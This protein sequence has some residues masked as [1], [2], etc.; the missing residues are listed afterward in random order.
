MSRSST[1]A[2]RSSLPS[3]PSSTWSAGDW[4]TPLP[5]R[6]GLP[7]NSDPDQAQQTA[8]SGEHVTIEID[9]TSTLDH[10]I[11]FQL[12]MA[13]SEELDDYLPVMNCVEENESPDSS[14]GS[15]GRETAPGGGRKGPAQPPGLPLDSAADWS[16]T[17]SRRDRSPRSSQQQGSEGHHIQ[18][19]N[20]HGKAAKER[21][22]NKGQ[23]GGFVL[24]KSRSVQALV[25]PQRYNVPG[26]SPADSSITMLLS[27]ELPKRSLA[28][29][30]K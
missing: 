30:V 23:L 25:V 13:S 11:E 7:D 5:G 9:I 4:L 29:H 21:G 1:T 20:D 27:Q 19:Q 17:L 24:S 18:K 28:S 6:P 8:D 3:R 26:P 12:A 14:R 15:S 22:S 2:E 10:E 16:E